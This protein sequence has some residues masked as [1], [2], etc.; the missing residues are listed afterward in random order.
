MLILSLIDRA[1]AFIEIP[2]VRSC[3]RIY[4][5][6]GLG[7]RLFIKFPSGCSPSPY[8]RRGKVPSGNAVDRHPAPSRT[9]IQE[10]H[11]ITFDDDI[12]SCWVPRNLGPH[13]APYNVG[14]HPQE[15]ALSPSFEREE[16][17]SLEVPPGEM[18]STQ[19]IS[20]PPFLSPRAG[21]WK[22]PEDVG[23]C[24]DTHSRPS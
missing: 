11:G 19:G 18:F 14:F 21:T 13:E 3:Y 4:G 10:S 9:R 8:D 23:P 15:V 16:T 12:R 5:Y 20:G 7:D 22:G 2:A 17:G 6:L 24:D 1:I